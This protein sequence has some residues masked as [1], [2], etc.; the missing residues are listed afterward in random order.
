MT[1]EIEE[2]KG[3]IA[4]YFPDVEPVSETVLKFT[5][6]HGA[7]PFAVF[8][9][10]VG[11]KLPETPEQLGEYQDRIIAKNYFRD[12]VRLQWNHY[13]YF[14]TD[15]DLQQDDD[16]KRVRALIEADRK[17]AR[18]HVVNESDLEG[19]L[20][21]PIIHP[22]KPLQRENILSLWTQILEGADIEKAILTDTTMPARLEMIANASDR[23]RRPQ[24][25]TAPKLVPRSLP[26]IST[27]RLAKY[28]PYP[29]RREFNFGRVNLIV[30]R[31]GVGKTS[32]LEAIELF[33]CGKNKRNVDRTGPYD[34]H[35]TY[36]DQTQERATSERSKQELRDRN[37]VWYGQHE[38][39]T[40][41]LCYSFGRFNFLD[42]D[43]AVG[44]SE[45]TGHIDESL[46]SLLVGADASQAWSTVERV[47]EE[48]NRRI[49]EHTHRASGLVAEKKD[50]EG[51]LL[52][53]SAKDQSKF[54]F[55]ELKTLLR[56]NGWLTFTED[57]LE[58]I[59]LLL[60]W[61]PQIKSIGHETE[62]LVDWIDA[63]ISIQTIESYLGKTQPKMHFAFLGMQELLQ[64]DEAEKRITLEMRDDREALDLLERLKQFALLNI[65]AKLEKSRALEGKLTGIVLALDNIDDQVV[66]DLR[67][68]DSGVLVEEARQRVTESKSK[69]RSAVAV[70]KRNYAN[71]SKLRE[72]SARLEQELREIGR[73]IVDISGED[74]VCPLCDSV[75]DPE[76]FSEHLR[77]NHANAED[78]QGK[79]LLDDI[80]EAERK[81]N[82]SIELDDSLD[83]AVRFLA[84][85]EKR[86]QITVGQAIQ[87]IEAA[88][89]A[90]VEQRLEID[91]VNSDLESH[92]REGISLLEMDEI[93]SRL[94]ELKVE[95]GEI[96]LDHL[97][98]VS[99]DLSSRQE[100]GRIALESARMGIRSR[101]EFLA[102]ML[103]E[104]DRTLDATRVL[105]TNVQA[106]VAAAESARA[107]L[108]EINERF[109]WPTSGSIAEMSTQATYMLTLVQDYKGAFEREQ[110][111]RMQ[112][113]S[114][115]TQLEKATSTLNQTTRRL[116]RFTKAQ[117]ALNT[118]RFRHSL[119]AA[120]DATLRE[121][122]SA[123][124]SIFAY[125]HSPAEFKG[126]GENWNELV[127]NGSDQ[128]ATLSEIS[129]GQRAAFGLSLF[130]AQNGQLAS[131]P[132]VM[133]IDDPIAHIDDLNALS[134]LDYLR[135]IAVVD[136]KQ[137]F[138]ATANEKV[139]A[140]FRR[141]FDFLSD[142]EFRVIE[143][144]RESEIV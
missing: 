55:D 133:L 115:T 103:G 110:S 135:E 32:L 14:V 52:N 33:Y 7:T 47:S 104:S 64:H 124:E 75:V 9:F 83:R 40:N 3:R 19:V 29:L 125:I 20:R 46:A 43:A 91:R 6:R 51:R 81:L 45:S 121:N 123:V 48:L 36:K 94:R 42:T 71:F 99:A 59:Q 100:R 144:S 114:L 77:G 107:K 22:H 38:I 56:R 95:V 143:L 27:L 122:R 26:Q 69:E 8:Y 37:L 72:Q 105:L 134:F 65:P 25:S 130:L 23:D 119:T 79:R 53:A 11:N 54:I 44:L 50:L 12:E 5:R 111:M 140:I 58:T 2:V 101:L 90:L 87:E 17:F 85:L 41:D 98:Y 39:K 24:R 113:Q 13:L 112:V 93:Q 139:A 88:T 132:P 66:E 106:R 127:R 138:F 102:M 92:Q 74:G 63:P 108:L 118:I 116:G 73:K 78:I 86:V 4:R 1:V 30:G 35:V 61:L 70:A 18:K 28:R 57:R 142:S 34:I 67:E 96:S 89:S 129:T 126:M 16:V 84:S 128:T 49:E 31:N 76:S 80:N 136:G 62:Q 131:A 137:N 82:K 68:V 97:S 109:P 10:D 15:R 60:H 117:A 21:P 141:K 120:M